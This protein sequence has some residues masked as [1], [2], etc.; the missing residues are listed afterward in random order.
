VADV[1]LK[2]NASTSQGGYICAFRAWN[3][4][5][6]HLKVDEALSRVVD[7]GHNHITIAHM[8]ALAENRT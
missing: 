8:S 1:E 4:S 7:S 2:P 5:G 6:A 3:K